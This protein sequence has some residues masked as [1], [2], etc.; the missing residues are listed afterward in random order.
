ML[1]SITTVILVIVGSFVGLIALAF[2]A[3]LVKA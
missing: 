3:L 2:L 1:A